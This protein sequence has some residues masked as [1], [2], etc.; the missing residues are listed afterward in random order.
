M[1]MTQ[2]KDLRFLQKQAQEG[3]ERAQY[4][5]ARHYIEQRDYAAAAYWLQKAANQG[6]TLAANQLKDVI[7][8]GMRRK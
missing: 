4:D 3:R 2:N 8:N 7:N 5:L 1:N 6:F